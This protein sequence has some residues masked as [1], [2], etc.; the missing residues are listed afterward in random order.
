[1][2]RPAAFAVAVAIVVAPKLSLAAPV[3]N[4]AQIKQAIIQDSIA[5]YPGPCACPYNLARNGS[6]CGRRSAYSRPGGYAPLCYASDISTE[7]VAAYRRSHPGGD[8]RHPRE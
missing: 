3:Q 7:D 2:L 1:M 8:V 5:S 4:D 6:H